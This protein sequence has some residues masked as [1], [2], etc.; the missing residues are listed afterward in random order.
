MQEINN[1]NI[2]TNIDETVNDSTESVDVHNNIETTTKA[3]EKLFTQDEL[4]NILEKR[5]NKEKAKWRNE[6]DQAKRL[7]EMSAEER[8]KAEFEIEKKDFERQRQEFNRERLL[9]QTQKE[10]D[11]V[12]VPIEFAEMLVKTDAE[13]TKAAIDDFTALYSKSVEKGVSNRLKGRPP[14]TKQSTAPSDGLTKA[15]FM[16]MSLAQQQKMARENP[17][18]YK[19][20]IK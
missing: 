8:A 9:L 20:L 4:N 7:A 5:L 6:I 11:A 19:E 18:R 12:N 3:Q 10:L 16:K 1:T 15:S 17:E 13:S 2:N 14:K